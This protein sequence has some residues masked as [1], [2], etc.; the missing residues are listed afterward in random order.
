MCI[1]IYTTHTHTHVYIYKVNNW[2]K[3]KKKN[4]SLKIKK[5]KIKQKLKK[6]HFQNN[7]KNLRKFVF[8]SIWFYELATFSL[9]T[10]FPPVLVF[11][12]YPLVKYKTHS[13]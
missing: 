12:P 1:Y 3:S 2:S 9:R 5:K 4:V 11:P 13:N 8:I 6:K 7:K 10:F